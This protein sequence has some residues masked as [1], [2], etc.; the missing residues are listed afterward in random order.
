M[1]KLLKTTITTILMVIGLGSTV[2]TQTPQEESLNQR[3]QRTQ[4]TEDCDSNIINIKDNLIK[5][6]IEPDT[7]YREM[8]GMSLPFYLDSTMVKN[9][10]SDS[11]LSTVY[12]RA[13]KIL[14]KY[15]TETLINT[16]K[17][18][19]F[20]FMDNPQDQIM[21]GKD[22]VELFDVTFNTKDYSIPLSMFYR[23]YEPTLETPEHAGRKKEE[24]YYLLEV[25]YVVTFNT[26]R[27]Y[28]EF[29]IE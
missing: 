17:Q 22:T 26:I 3:I 19:R 18:R 23:L 5:V 6:M 13:R 7:I 14:E 8:V 20:V 25:G 4:L 27:V 9:A 1:K 24:D 11:L 16:Y 28:P 12:L 10:K 21:V 15:L 2:Y 29:L